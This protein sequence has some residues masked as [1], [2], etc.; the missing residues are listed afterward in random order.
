M[1]P[2]NYQHHLDVYLRYTIVKLCQEKRSLAVPLVF[3]MGG[4]CRAED[5][6]RY[7]EPRWVVGPEVLQSVQQPK[8]SKYLYIY[9]CVYIIYIYIYTGPKVRIQQPVEGQVY[10]IAHPQKEPIF[11]ETAI[12][13]AG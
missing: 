9:I 13:L 4:G 2:K 3:I 6:K 1:G 5:Y 8:G 7:V 12:S 11:M 10:A